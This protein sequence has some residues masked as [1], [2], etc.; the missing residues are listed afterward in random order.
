MAWGLWIDHQLNEND[1]QKWKETLVNTIKGGVGWR[2][3]LLQRIDLKVFDSSSSSPCHVHL[4]VLTCVFFWKIPQGKEE[5]AW[6]S[7]KE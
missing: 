7:G 4:L 2:S 1:Q 5:G 3:R 6:T